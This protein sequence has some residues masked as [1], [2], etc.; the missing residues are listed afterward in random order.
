M[1]VSQFA[2]A[3]YTGHSPRVPLVLPL[4]KEYCVNQ[5]MD[6][7]LKAVNAEDPAALRYFSGEPDLPPG[8]QISVA[9]KEIAPNFE[10]DGVLRITTPDGFS[11]LDHSEFK[12]RYRSG[13]QIQRMKYG[14]ALYLGP[15]TLPIRSTMFVILPDHFLKNYEELPPYE[16]PGVVSLRFRT[17]KVWELEAERALKWPRP[18]L[19]SIAPFMKSNR[20]QEREAARRLKGNTSS[21]M[22]FDAAMKVKYDKNEV[23]GFWEEIDMDIAERMVSLTVPTTKWGQEMIERESRPLVEASLQRGIEQ[24]LEKGLMKGR[25]EGLRKGMLQA[26]LDL[27]S[28]WRDFRGRAAGI[29][30][31]RAWRPDSFD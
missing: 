1:A 29:R 16:A 31:A 6:R 8:S 28:R 26:S 15:E 2:A 12:S 18:S 7:I 3:C 20:E 27:G 23:A 14:F 19:L 13:T 25:E 4:R 5:P 21:R 10:V 9:S 11:W 30:G 17:L 22:L 24:G